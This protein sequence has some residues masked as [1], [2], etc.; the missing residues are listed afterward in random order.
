VGRGKSCSG[1][2]LRRLFRGA[3]A[4]SWEGER[5]AEK[6]MMVDV[7]RVLVRS[8]LSNEVCEVG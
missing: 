6:L 2:N 8:G 4:G 3:S 5:G 7:E 1:S